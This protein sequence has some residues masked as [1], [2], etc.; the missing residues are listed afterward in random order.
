MLF[1]TDMLLMPDNPFL[2][3]MLNGIAAAVMVLALSTAQ[4][5]CNI[6]WLVLGGKISYGIYMYHM[7]VIT[8]LIFIF[9]KLPVHGFSVVLGVNILSMVFTYLL[10]LLSYRLYES[11]FLKMKKY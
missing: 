11:K 6:E 9:Q 4:K 2:W 3:R 5:K 7:I 10:A 8:G 1:F